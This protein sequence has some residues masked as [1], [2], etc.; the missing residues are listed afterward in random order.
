MFRDD[1]LDPN[2]LA[3]TIAQS[4]CLALTSNLESLYNNGFT[5]I[6]L[7]VNLDPDKVNAGFLF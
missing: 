1:N 3:E 6:G 5:K 2:N 7:R 4:L